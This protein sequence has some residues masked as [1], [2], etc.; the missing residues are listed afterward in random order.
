M[1]L[2]YSPGTCSLA[3]HIIAQEI[4]LPLDLEKV[5]LAKKR[6]ASGIDFTTI[7]AKGY[8]PVLILDD[9]D[10]L[11]ENPAILH[12]VAAQSPQQDLVPEI[13]SRAYYRHLEWLGFVNSEVHKTFTPLW[14]PELSAEIRDAA[15]VKL[16]QRFALIE[17]HLA[18]HRYLLGEQ[19][20]LVDAYC[21]TVVNWSNYLRIDLSPYPYLQRYQTEIAARSAVKR[22][23]TAEGLL[24]A[25]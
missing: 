1:K 10:V 20:A 5:D 19:F 11:T 24:K 4:G 23:M 6:T 12:Y 21:F 8:V 22:A 9:G 13:G 16:L 15:R 2:Y 17:Q 18:Q 7:N 3:A 25:A 14:H